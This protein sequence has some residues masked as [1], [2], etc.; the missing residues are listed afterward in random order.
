MRI[1]IT[2]NYDDMSNIATDII[3][4]QLILNPDSVLGL[5][6]GSTPT[7]MYEGLVKLYNE[8]RIDFKDVVT[9]N[10]DEYCGLPDENDQSYHYF[11]DKNLLSK[12][13]VAPENINI[14]SGVEDDMEKTCIEYD[15]K[16]Q[17][18]GGTDIQVLGIGVNGHIGFNE[19][20]DVFVGETHIID[21]D[22]T[23]IEA[24]AR[25]FEK[26]DDVPK[27][28]ITMGMRSIMSAGRIL[29]MASGS[30]KAKAIYD[31]IKGPITPLVPASILQLHEDVIVVVDKEAAKLITDMV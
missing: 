21:L 14:P 10:L 5:A 28:A 9:F 23:T 18:F 25:F 13:N 1:I 3:A 24:N 22:E 15:E 2:E 26:K 29:L 30:G 16:I 6:T 12:V 4:A 17:S 8:G 7:G 20:G 27:Q 19:P 31:A 11:M